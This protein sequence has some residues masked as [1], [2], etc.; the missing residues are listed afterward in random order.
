M[1]TN[2][3][4]TYTCDACSRLY[5]KAADLINL[6]VTPALDADCRAAVLPRDRHFCDW[7]C[8]IAW[9]QKQKEKNNMRPLGQFG[10]YGPTERNAT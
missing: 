5:D 8:V 9:A 6:D 4:M 10:V 2:W 7:D 3:T 1:T